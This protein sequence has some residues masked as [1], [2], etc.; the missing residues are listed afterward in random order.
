MENIVYLLGSGFSAPMGIP[1]MS[2]FLSASKDVYRSNQQRY[3][4]F[5]DIFRDIEHLNAVLKYCKSDLFNI[6]E[7]LSIFEMEEYLSGGNKATVFRKY[8][9]DVVRFYSKEINPAKVPHNTSNWKDFVW[10]NDEIW[11]R[12]GWFIANLLRLRLKS[13]AFENNDGTLRFAYDQ[14]G[15]SEYHYGVITLNYDTILDSLIKYINAYWANLTLYDND[16]GQH[17]DSQHTKVIPFPL[18]KIHGCIDNPESI[19]LPTWRKGSDTSQDALS[20]WK[21]AFKLLAEANQIRILG[22]SFPES[23]YYMQYLLKSALVKS[24]HLKSI[25]LICRD[26]KGEVENRF[27]KLIQFKFKRFIKA[28]I[29][30]Y[31]DA[32]V[33]LEL[34]YIRVHREKSK[35]I[36]VSQLEIVHSEFIG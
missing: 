11:K 27:H 22:Y 4:Y 10:G 21:T 7:I 26:S 3:S 31:F 2:N 5:S 36:D 24:E 35:Y 15:K 16:G 12:Y 23:D 25:D 34:E 19:I 8:I 9:A 28:R 17:T 14:A 6:E 13:G 29:E 32:I 1:I 18:A 33:K 20:E 30:D